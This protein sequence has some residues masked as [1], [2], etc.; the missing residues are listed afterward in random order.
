MPR[1][2]DVLESDPLYEQAMALA[3]ARIARLHEAAR[4]EAREFLE[5]K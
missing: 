4:T 3:E 2:F 5:A 1:S